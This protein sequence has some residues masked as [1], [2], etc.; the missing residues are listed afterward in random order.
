[1]SHDVQKRT[2]LW[3]ALGHLLLVL[4]VLF[5]LRFFW[6]PEEVRYIEMVSLGEL[7]PG[8]GTPQPPTASGATQAAAP[9]KP[10]PPTPD[11]APPLPAPAPP[12]V[13]PTPAPA[14]A[15]AP[16]PSPAPAPAPTPPKPPTPAPPKPAPTPP[17]K[18]EVDLTRKVVRD[19][20]TTA[21]RQDGPAPKP[22]NARTPSAGEVEKNLRQSLEKAG[23]QGGRGAGQAG[24]PDGSTEDFAWYHALIKDTIRRHWIKPNLEARFETFATI[25][26]APDGRVTLLGLAKSSGNDQVD[27]SVLNAIRAVTKLPQPLPKGLGSPNYEVTVNFRLD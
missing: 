15:P 4:A 26:I 9:P 21:A 27:E 16:A 11:P 14:P 23:I 5:P 3:V 17:R 7:N 13:P 6:K 8:E 24:R 10:T 20:S 25:R 19:T 22:S 2:L 12:L 1:M 18:I